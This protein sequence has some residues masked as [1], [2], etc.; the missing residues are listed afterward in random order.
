MPFFVYSFLTDSGEIVKDMGNYPSIDELYEDLSRLGGELY[1]VVA[2]PEFIEP[3]YKGIVV[4]K[5]RLKDIAEFVRNVATY[6]ESGVSVQEALEDLS[7]TADSKAIRYASQKILKTLAEGYTFSEALDKVGFFPNIVVSMAKIGEAS[8]NMDATLKDA[9]DYLDRVISI[10]SAAKRAMVYPIF[11]LL[12][13]LGAFA[14]WT[15]Y[16]LPKLTDL[17]TSQGMQLPLATRML[18]SISNFMQNYWYA[19]FIF[20]IAI[21][22][23]FP[24]F[25]RL[26]KFRYYVHEFLWKA[27]IVGLIVRNSQVAFYFQYLALLTS[28]GVTITESLETMEN[29]VT[30]DYFLKAIGGMNEKLRAGRS[31]SEVIKKANIFDRI[32]VRMIAV[33]EVTGNMDEQMR[34]LSDMYF[35]KVQNLVEVI[36]K[37]IEPVILGFIGVIFIFFVLALIQPIYNMIGNIGRY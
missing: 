31:L 20:L 2:L 18:I 34:R 25:M 15:V 13:I 5:P 23:S 14:F 32:V 17:F 26:K 7:E 29:A 3:I 12:A 37:L 24:F 10:R 28:S 30:N 36:G 33:G 8:G 21:V 19:L 16:V 1:R 11:S 4:G 6:L 27:P 9:A 35:E 22:L